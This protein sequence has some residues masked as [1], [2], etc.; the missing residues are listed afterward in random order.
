MRVMI[1]S[2]NNVHSPDYHAEITAEKIISAA[3]TSVISIANSSPHASIGREVR[4]R[5]ER[6]LLKHHQ[7]VH[8]HECS[9]LEAKGLDHCD[10]DLD[11]HPHVDEEMLDEIAA[12]AL[13]T[14]LHQYFLRQD[15][16]EGILSELH[17]ETRSQM[18]VHRSVHRESE[19]LKNRP[20]AVS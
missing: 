15:V 3:E 4:K 6:E 9:E 8:D 12:A 2:G 11:S 5:I 17:H 13:G 10:C 14:P 1:T 20:R 16:R 7:A 19:R 18:H